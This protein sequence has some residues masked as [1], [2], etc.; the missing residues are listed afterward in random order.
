MTFLAPW[1]LCGLAALPL[2]AFLHMF[3][4]RLVERRVA[5][6]F[7]FPRVPQTTY[8]G[9]TFTKLVTTASLVFELLAATFLV[10]W[11]SR[12]V[13]GPRET[14]EHLVVVLDDSAS[15]QA[16]GAH[17]RAVDRA[18]ADVE[19]IAGELGRNARVTLI[20]TGPR[21]AVILGPQAPMASASS[22]LN[23][24]TPSQRHH[25]P[26]PALALAMQ[27]SAPGDRLTYVTDDG[28]ATAP[29]RWEVRMVG[30]V[31]P[32]AA[33]S[34]VRRVRESGHDVLVVDVRGFG[35]APIQTKLVASTESDPP[36]PLST[37]SLT[38]SGGTAT[39][40][41]I[42]LPPATGAVRLKLSPDALAIDDERLVLPEPPRVVRV[43]SLLK[44][45]W[46]T[47][48]RIDRVVGA[49]EDARLVTSVSDAD[50]VFAPGPGAL[51]G[52]RQE[53]VIGRR[54]EKENAWVGPYLLDHR[55]GFLV[56]LTLQ[57]VVWV[58]GELAP[59]G[60]VILAAGDDVLA[61]EERVGDASRLWLNLDPERGN[62]ALAP[63]WP[64]LVSNVVERAR[65]RLPGMIAANVRLGDEIVWRPRESVAG[66]KWELI[67]PGGGTLSG[68]GGR[69]VGF[70][71]R[72]AGLHSIRLDGRE[73]ARASVF[74]EDP[75][76]SDLTTAA[77][78]HRPAESIDHA[79][80]GAEAGRLESRVL[81]L[82]ALLFLGL[83]WWVLRK[84]AGTW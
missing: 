7:L 44:E 56:G 71:P 1:A 43:A 59:P 31:S 37:T 77:T 79:N 52:T 68:V 14:V 35:R 38:L 65:A 13:I 78:R 58:A 39:R 30:E 57:G 46:A 74:F 49:I 6:L 12:P 67:E 40:T 69:E 76:E 53:I 64:I 9:R 63:D 11:L 16:V 48:L 60:I 34:G 33:I 83:D 24:W 29:P 82:L 66:G 23:A 19:R 25:D 80:E 26:E 4:R 70:A 22:A 41:Q 32:N 36:Q 54:G 47:A 3:R 45:A 20:T 5:G 51:R 8:G 55:N 28:A 21:P 42:P 2:I 15:M 17:D 10:L 75:V 72:R 50:V 62:L 73:L 27:L 84:G 18:R 81:A 61:S